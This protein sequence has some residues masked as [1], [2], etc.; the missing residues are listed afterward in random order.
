[1]SK[2]LVFA[3]ALLAAAQ[4]P[5]PQQPRFRGGTNFVQVDVFA[6]R[7]GVPVQDLTAADFELYDDDDSQK[8]ESFE[9]IVVSPAGPQ[10]ERIDPS[11]PT[12]ANQLA[13]DPHRRVFV[14]FLDFFHVSVEGSHRI[15]EP[16]IEMMS[17][18][19]GPDD[20]V[21]IM[22]PDM[23]PSQI[24]LGRK[25]QVIEQG[26]R[27]KWY[28]GRR[29]SLRQDNYEEMYKS[30][31]PPLFFSGGTPLAQAMIERRAER[32]VLESLNDTILHMASIREG[33]TA[34]IAVTDGWVLYRPDQS[35]TVL[36]KDPLTGKDEPIPGMPPPPRVGSGGT[37]TTKETRHGFEEEQ[38]TC[39]RDRM[40]LAMMDDW[41]YF[42]DLFGEA[43]RA[44]VSFYPVDPR[45]LSAFDSPIGPEPPPDL[46]TDHVNLRARNESLRMLADNTDGLALVDNNDL[47]KQLRRVADD[48][49][50]YYLIGYYST[51][52]KLDG[53]FHSIKVR[54]KRPGVDVRARKGYR[55]PTAAEVNASIT[56]SPSAAAAIPD[57]KTAILVALNMLER[58]A[59]IDES[60]GTMASRISSLE[61]PALFRRGP[62]TGNALQ[63]APTRRLFRSDRLHVEAVAGEVPSWTGVLLDRTGKRLPVPV[64]AGA[65]TNASGERV[66]TAD[67]VLAPLA[68]GDYLL[69]LIYTRNGASQRVLAPFRLASQ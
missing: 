60:R 20:L 67:V 11:S 64:S 50:S 9:H 22:T 38:S 21:G 48:L 54:A 57:D 39:D 68:A 1:M 42:R 18:I 46:V 35:L 32:V 45:G 51:K 14:I 34:V 16:L 44:N 2:Y 13:A 43:N 33:R 23:S 58:D 12:I 30:C 17:R 24:T 15:K 31:Y 36:R 28:W 55:A 62:L 63:P 7:D 6:T 41:Q 19:V 56:T 40:T 29:D 52:N 8:I 3:A 65:N 37:L 25:T 10:P 4:Q 5:A 59:R 66:L 49:T 53:R 69:E 47:R 27:D 61:S 26:L